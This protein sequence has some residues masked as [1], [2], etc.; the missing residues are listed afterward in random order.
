MI[1]PRR[2]KDLH[3]GSYLLSLLTAVAIRSALKQGATMVLP[4]ADLDSTNWLEGQADLP[5]FPKT[6]NRLM[7]QCRADFDPEVVVQD[8][9]KAFKG[10]AERIWAQ[11]FGDFS[12]FEQ[13]SFDQHITR[14]IWDRQVENYLHIQWVISEE[15]QLN[16]LDQRK[17]MV[18]QFPP[19]E[20]GYKCMI[21]PGL[22]E[23]SGND[24]L[25]SNNRHRFWEMVNE[26]H[27]HDYKQFYDIQ[28]DQVQ[29]EH[30][31]AIAFIKRHFYQFCSTQPVP[32]IELPSFTLKL[33]YQTSL[34]YLQHIPS[35]LEIA[36]SINPKS[37]FYAILAMD[38]DQ[39]GK[40]LHNE[41]LRHLIKQH[42]NPFMDK[43][44]AEFKPPSSKKKP[45]NLLIYCGGEDI[46]AML[47]VD[48]ALEMA[49][50]LRQH[51]V[52]AFAKITHETTQ[53]SLTI[54]AAIVFCQYK[55]PMMQSI[56]RANE[57]LHQVA[58]EQ[59]GRNALAIEVNKPSGR[60][61]TWCLPWDATLSKPSSESD[62]HEKF[63]TVL[64]ENNHMTMQTLVDILKKN[65]RAAEQSNKDSAATFSTKFL[66]RFRENYQRLYQTI[67]DQ[68]EL[69]KQLI[70]A[71][72][73]RSGVGQHAE[74]FV[75]KL[76]DQS[77]VVNNQQL[78]PD[79]M[80]DASAM[81]AR[82]IAS[83]GV[84]HDHSSRQD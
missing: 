73:R 67:G 51:F 3:S 56:N 82:F 64:D 40:A 7:A 28:S 47:P 1:R 55:M 50:T 45:D 31:C 13:A 60:L 30:L 59:V 22:Q 21:M 11:Y 10:I 27:L 75:E 24:D 71:D 34:G 63:P 14:A 74:D 49:Q 26:L 41:D 79:Q 35:T 62:N 8:C 36:R 80:S 65:D 83:G 81:I 66:Y 15:H 20:P 48:Q 42:L 38:G 12:R 61:G 46:L 76:I 52:D 2:T 29:I 33:R 69:L 4:N 18:N 44:S 43:V 70:L 5:I 9:Q 77:K 6:P 68:P 37:T 16:A 32:V 53:P 19:P 58:K 23:L 78:K 84:I 72:Y 17:N 54:S 25:S 57:L 39:F